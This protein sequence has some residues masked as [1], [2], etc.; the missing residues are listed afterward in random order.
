MG[1]Q[2]QSEKRP[3]GYGD[4]DQDRG[5]E[6]HDGQAGGADEEGQRIEQLGELRFRAV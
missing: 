3:H 5:H 2:R 6:R 1:Q 4:P